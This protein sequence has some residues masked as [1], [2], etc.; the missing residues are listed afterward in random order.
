MPNT[1]NRRNLKALMDLLSDSHAEITATATEVNTALIEADQGG[2]GQSF[3]QPYANRRLD[4]L[5]ALL[6][7]QSA[8]ALRVIS[9]VE[10]IQK[11]IRVI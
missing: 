10:E 6:T 7:A 4:A 5:T 1:A 11:N 9:E 2:R 8:R 3:K